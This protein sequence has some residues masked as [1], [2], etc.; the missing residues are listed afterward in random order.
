MG[1]DCHSFGSHKT[2]QDIASQMLTHFSNKSLFVLRAL[3]H[4]RKSDRLLQNIALFHG[5]NACN[6]D[7]L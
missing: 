3:Q 5:L 6:V 1:K 2:V 7:N 4:Q